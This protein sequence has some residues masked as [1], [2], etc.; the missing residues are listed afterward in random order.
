MHAMV[1]LALFAASPNVVFISCDTLRPDH[2]GCYGYDKNTSPSIDKLATNSLVFDDAVCEVPLTNPSFVSMMTSRVPRMLG[3]TRNGLRLPDSVPTVAD[4]FRAAG[5][6]TFCVQSN[7]TLKARLSGLDRGFDVY[8]D[9]FHTKRWGVIISER[10]ADA[11]TRIALERLAQR[12]PHRPFFAWIH[13]SDPHAPYRFHSDVNPGGKPWR[14]LDR[15]NQVRA[16][17][18]SEV[19]Y[20][21]SFVGQVLSALPADTYVVFAAD[22]GESLYE[23][24]YLGHGRRLYQSG[25]R[26]PLLVHGPGIGAGRSAAPARGLDVGPTLLGLAGLTLPGAMGLDLLRAAPGPDR[27]RVVETYGGAVPRLPG[28]RALLA[29]SGPQRQSVVSDGWK[30][31]VTGPKTEL[32]RLSDDPGELRNLAES[33]DDKV[34]ALTRLIHDWNE[35]MPRGTSHDPGLSADDLNALESLGYLK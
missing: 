21:D 3:A 26:I 31:I 32:Y 8:D 11:V 23:H 25:V 33:S 22:H 19:A 5:Y 15:A 16:L 7:W 10:Y 4:L 6:Q 12:D 29:G 17:Y 14:R 28:A 34:K 20:M 13:Y 30:L 2:L 18:D 1:L 24:N 9:A 35:R 27:I